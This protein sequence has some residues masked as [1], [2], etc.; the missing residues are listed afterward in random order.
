MQ[1]LGFHAAPLPLTE[2]PGV[3]N[4]GA[5]SD[6]IYDDGYVKLDEGTLNPDA[7]GGLGNTWNWA[8]NDSGQFNSAANTLS[9]RK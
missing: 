7:V 8:Y 2:P 5:H 6:R 3:G 1:T 9:F 4:P